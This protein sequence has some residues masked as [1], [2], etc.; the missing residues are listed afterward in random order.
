MLTRIQLDELR[1]IAEAILVGQSWDDLPWDD[2]WRGVYPRQPEVSDIEKEVLILKEKV[3]RI[4]S[5]GSIE[6]EY[7]DLLEHT[8]MIYLERAKS[9][10]LFQRVPCQ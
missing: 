6:T 4:W 2:A 8:R 7:E 10:N 3:Y 9:I 5:T 1:Q